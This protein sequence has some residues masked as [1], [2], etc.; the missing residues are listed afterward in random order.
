M[1]GPV[2]RDR[3]APATT[4]GRIGIREI[5]LLLTN[6]C[7]LT[8]RHCY[9]ASHLDAEY[10]LSTDR[11]LR[12][13]D[14][15]YDEL[16]PV[17]FVLSGG[18]ALLR[19]RDCL[20]I[21]EYA[22]RKHE[23][24][25]ISNGTLI[26]PRLARALASFDMDIKISLDGGS[27]AAHDAMRGEG[28]FKRAARGLE[29]LRTAGFHPA[30]IQ[31]GSVLTPHTLDEVAP[32]L[33]LGEQFG[34]PMVRFDA[35]NKIGRARQHWLVVPG[36][37]SDPDSIPFKNYFSQ[38]FAQCHGDTW[39]LIDVDHAV[40]PF[41]CLQIYYD[42]SVFPYTP[43]DLSAEREN[44]VGNINEQSLHDVLAGPQLPHTILKKIVAQHQGP[45]SS[46]RSFYAVRRTM[47]L[48]NAARVLG[49]SLEKLMREM[50]G[51]A[52]DRPT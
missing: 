47:P 23:I 24:K 12:L 50:D 36:N 35:L 51:R 37:R 30:H 22:A 27:S 19:S 52:S 8:C 20:A 7:N 39:H 28:S 25:V 15:C 42:G 48:A 31:I 33:A 45:A 17:R 3:A 21:L 1:T 43:F 34:V 44:R 4:L 2:L 38:S 32:L 18:E 13:I 41:D 16:G 10:G 6:R 5:L 14:E 9:T 49:I 46:V 29:A 26:G 11:V 40:P